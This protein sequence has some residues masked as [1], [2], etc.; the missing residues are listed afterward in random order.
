MKELGAEVGGGLI[1]HMA[2]NTYFTVHVAI[3]TTEVTSLHVVTTTYPT[4]SLLHILAMTNF[5][6]HSPPHMP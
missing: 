6:V 2:Y 5:P 3:H 4:Y 1:I